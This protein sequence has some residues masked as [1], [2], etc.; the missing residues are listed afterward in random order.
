MVV[1]PDDVDLL[2]SLIPAER[3]R[4]VEALERRGDPLSVELLVGRISDA[5]VDVLHEA[6]R[7]LGRIGSDAAV[8]GLTAVALDEHQVIVRRVVAALAMGSV[9]G[10]GEHAVAALRRLLQDRDPWVRR[11][12]REALVRL[13]RY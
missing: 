11:A 9:R 12:A 4:A 5:D 3:L 10:I 2:D 8:Q 1:D 7:A 6:A 13:M